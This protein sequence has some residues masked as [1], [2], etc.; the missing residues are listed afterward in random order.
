MENIFLKGLESLISCDIVPRWRLGRLAQT[1]YVRQLFERMSTDCVLDVGANVGQYRDYLREEVGFSGLIISFEPHP[2]CVAKL[3]ERA[4]K[5]PKWVIHGHALGA[6]EGTL[7]LNQTKDSE[8]SS[9]LQPEVS[10]FTGQYIGKFNVIEKTAPVAVHTLN[11]IYSDLVTKNKFTKPFLKLD[12]QGFDL[13]VIKGAD[14]ILS[15]FAAIQSEVS[16]LPIYDG[17][18]TLADTLK[19][20]NERG[21]E[22]GTFFPA[23]PGQFPAVVDFD[24]YFISRSNFD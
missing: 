15:K 14:E 4:V 17:I 18:P 13:Q 11:N 16:N 23:N 20:F 3:R 21:F 1:E 2:N 9:F 12:T 6:R 8:F 7:E 24:T 22:L 5:D 19:F 10:R